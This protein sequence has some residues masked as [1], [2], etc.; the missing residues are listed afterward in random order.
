VHGF[1]A[2]VG[3]RRPQWLHPARHPIVIF[4]LRLKL[5]SRVGDQQKTVARNIGRD[6]L[7]HILAQKGPV[8]RAR[9]PVELAAGSG[10]CCAA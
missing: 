4:N 1:A 2:V 6:I 7:G 5:G 8:V 9:D 10:D 3:R